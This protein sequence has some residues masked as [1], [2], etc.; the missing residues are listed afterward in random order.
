MDI[1]INILEKLDLHLFAAN[2]STHQK[3][4]YTS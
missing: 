4:Y 3:L 1:S 2:V